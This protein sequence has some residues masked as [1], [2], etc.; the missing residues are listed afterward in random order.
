MDQYYC[1]LLLHAKMLKE[2]ESKETIVVFV[3]F[4]SLVAFQLRGARA[5]L[6]TMDTPI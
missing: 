5:P 6:T 4:L 1:Y 3:T 2:I